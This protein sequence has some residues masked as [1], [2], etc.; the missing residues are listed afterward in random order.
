M[1]AQGDYEQEGLISS[2]R[3]WVR[4]CVFAN[5]ELRTWTSAHPEL[6]RAWDEAVREDQARAAR[7]EQGGAR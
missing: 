5:H 7:T 4:R 1:V 2:D 6:A 3:F